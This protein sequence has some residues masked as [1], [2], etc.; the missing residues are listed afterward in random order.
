MGDTVHTIP[1]NDLIEHD[2][3]GEQCVCGPETLPVECD[4]GSIAYNVV[5][6]SLDGREIQ[7]PDRDR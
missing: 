1:V 5:H 3:S 7:E 6:H 4:D 2:T